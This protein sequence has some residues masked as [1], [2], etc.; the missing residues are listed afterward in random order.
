MVA[1]INYLIHIFKI[2][3]RVPHPNPPCSNVGFIDIEESKLC[4]LCVVPE[5]K[6]IIEKVG[7]KRSDLIIVFFIFFLVIY[8]YLIIIYLK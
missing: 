3:L 8:L 6:S 1:D 7:I 4:N 5:P 2:E